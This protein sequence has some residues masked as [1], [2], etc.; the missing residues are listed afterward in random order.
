MEPDRN[1]ASSVPVAL[2]APLAILLAWWGAALI[3]TVLLRVIGL[4]SFEGMGLGDTALLH[5][6]D[7]GQ[8]MT[9]GLLIA[10]AVLAFGRWAGATRVLGWGLAALIAAG[11][12]VLFLRHDLQGPANRMTGGS[13]SMVPVLLLSA[14]MALS[15]PVMVWMTRWFARAR[16]RAVP[17]VGALGAMVANH[18]V[19]PGDYAGAHL[20][21]GTAA[22]SVAGAALRGTMVKPSRGLRWG[23]VGV[24]G[25]LALWVAA[26]PPPSKSVAAL[27]HSWARGITTVLPRTHWQDAFEA[28]PDGVAAMQLDAGT[29]N[30]PDATD[31]DASVPDS[32][33]LL[34]QNPVIIYYSVDSLRA[35]LLGPRYAKWFPQMHALK[36]ESVAFTQARSPSTKTTIALTTMMTGKYAAQL[37][38]SSK[39]VPE[40]K[41]TRAYYAHKDPSRHFPELLAE[42]GIPTAQYAQAVWLANEFRLTAGFTD[43]KVVPPVEGKPSTKGKW[44]TGEDVIELIFAR[45]RR[46]QQTDEPLFLFFHDLDPHYPFKLGKQKKGS[47]KRRYLSEM[48]LVDSR[49][50][51]LRRLLE[52][53]GLAE[54]AVLILSADHG[55]GF[56]EHGTKYH[57]QHLYDEQLRVPLLIQLPTKKAM[58]IDDYVSLIDLGPTILEMMGQPTPASSMGRSLVPYLAGEKPSLTRPLIFE[59]RAKEALLLPN[60]LKVIRDRKS[61]TRELYDL[62]TDPKESTNVFDEREAEAMNALGQLNAFFERHELRRK[63]YTN[64]IKR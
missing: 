23:L 14:G 63:G 43:S 35:D 21:L 50:G 64:R 36:K 19:L 28:P 25:V 39:F 16:R 12:G 55:E 62:K 56:G 37:Y 47:I 53:T 27:A 2:S 34:P 3:N 33:R 29:V 38:W 61:G 6:Y 59:V 58:L 48:K 31:E 52:T 15:V 30:Q 54:R 32:T 40:G 11:L 46:A 10:G 17:L 45:L 8:S 60:G 49:I 44:S 20:L 18:L 13:D 5:L 22:A 4:M 24:G 9:P 51:R 7:L 26:L 42:A 57:G 41:G 1:R